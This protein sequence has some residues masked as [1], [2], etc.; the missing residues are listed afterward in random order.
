MKLIILAFSLKI[1]GVIPQPEYSC[2]T[3]ISAT[4]F[5]Q[6]IQREFWHGLNC[7]LKAKSLTVKPM[8]S[9]V[10]NWLIPI[11]FGGKFRLRDHSI[12]GCSSQHA[13]VQKQQQQKEVMTARNNFYCCNG[14]YQ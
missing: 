11:Q 6:N 3:E 14:N 4:L 1:I 12:G 10:E 2:V 5:D 7:P 13:L 8:I 9:C